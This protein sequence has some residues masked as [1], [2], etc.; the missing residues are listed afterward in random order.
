MHVYKTVIESAL[1]PLFARATAVATTA[2]VARAAGVTRA[3]VVLAAA[4]IAM[5]GG[6]SAAMASDFATFEDATQAWRDSSAVWRTLPEDE[7]RA[8]MA[9]FLTQFG[10]ADLL[11]YCSSSHDPSVAGQLEGFIRARLSVSTLPVS[12]LIFLLTDPT[13]DASCKAGLMRHVNEIQD[14]L[15]DDEREAV[16]AAFLTM[17]DDGQFSPVIVKQI[18]I[19][20]AQFTT[21]DEMFERMEGY[22][23]SEDQERTGH[24]V[25]MLAR[26]PDPRSR[27]LL[28]DM[29]GGYRSRGE[30]PSRQI[31]LLA[32]PAVGA[33]GFGDLEALLDLAQIRRERESVLEAMA[34]SGEA[35]VLPLLLGEYGDQ[36]GRI[37]DS[38]FAIEDPQ[39]KDRFFQLYR[40]TRI[41]EPQLV[42][43]LAGDPSDLQGVALELLDRASRHGV[44]QQWP[45]LRAALTALRD[46]GGMGEPSQARI[47]RI[48]EQFE[49]QEARRE[50]RR[51]TRWRR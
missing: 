18:E 4:V 19:A 14:D 9:G 8:R 36:A 46:S 44:A 47:T 48:L 29:I 3:V 41:L 11:R 51:A 20:A 31:L 6:F 33:E 25:A 21:S 34:A 2:V 42:E 17:A 1:G 50:R 40:L 24:A 16:G 32:A 37:R 13:V 28:A 43:V 7:A 26:S 30:V 38:T 22:L 10:A 23:H 5:A 49:A 45:E 15:S 27:E 12:D 39:E 35:R